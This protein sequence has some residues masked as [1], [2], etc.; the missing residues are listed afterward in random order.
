[1]PMESGAIYPSK[2]LFKLHPPGI[3]P[4]GSSQYLLSAVY[5]EDGALSDS[6]KDTLEKKMSNWKHWLKKEP[7]NYIR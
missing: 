2:S 4:G 7:I 3:T 1:M 5:W 6:G